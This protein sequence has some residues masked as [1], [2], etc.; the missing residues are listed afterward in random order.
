MNSLDANVPSSAEGLNEYVLARMRALTPA[1]IGEVV[2]LYLDDRPQGI[3]LLLRKAASLDEVGLDPDA[4]PW[5]VASKAAQHAWR[6][7]MRTLKR[8]LERVRRSLKHLGIDVRIDNA[9]PWESRFLKILLAYFDASRGDA[10]RK[11]DLLM[12]EVIVDTSFDRSRLFNDESLYRNIGDRVLTEWGLDPSECRR[13]PAPL[14]PTYKHQ[15]VAVFLMQEFIDLT[16]YG[17]CLKLEDELTKAVRRLGCALAGLPTQLAIEPHSTVPYPGLLTLARLRLTSVLAAALKEFAEEG[18]TTL[19][20]RLNSRFAR[21]VHQALQRIAESVGAGASKAAVEQAVARDLLRYVEEFVQRD[22]SLALQ[23]RL[24][25]LSRYLESLPAPDQRVLFRPSGVRIRC[26]VFVEGP[27]DQI[28]VSSVSDKTTEG[29]HVLGITVVPSGSKEQMPPKVLDYR[30]VFPAVPI[31]C[32]LDAD[33]EAE[34]ATLIRML[35]TAPPGSACKRLTG[36]E[37]EDEVSSLSLAVALNEAYQNG[38]RIAPTDIDTSSRVVPQLEA[39][40]RKAKLAEFDKVALARHL[41]KIPQLRVSEELRAF[42]QDA[43]S[44]ALGNPEAAARA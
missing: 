25:Y 40:V 41:A 14:F 11:F 43:R 42:V 20:S 4:L 28:I 18:V 27:S 44:L 26:L 23:L 38:D 1:E 33:A 15:F 39:L 34:E 30:R 37:I 16:L 35:R 6:V 7:S 22:N 9:A 12:G 8:N 32:L 31:L 29:P 10:A 17:Y 3:A 36:G 13:L 21:L 24:H 2:R 5:E 19:P